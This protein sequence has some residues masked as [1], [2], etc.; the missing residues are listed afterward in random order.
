MLATGRM[1]HLIF[2]SSCTFPLCLHMLLL[3]ELKS[4]KLWGFE[5]VNK[6]VGPTHSVFVVQLTRVDGK[7]TVLWGRPQNEPCTPDFPVHA[8]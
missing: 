2:L 1:Y 6:P 7:T 5:R 8:R 4:S 3:S